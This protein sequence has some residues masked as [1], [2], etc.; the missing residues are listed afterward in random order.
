MFRNISRSARRPVWLLL[1][2][3]LL[4]ACELGFG[5]VESV[6]S[7]HVRQLIE[8]PVDSETTAELYRHM[9]NK[10]LVE[11]ARALHVQG[12]KLDYVA[13]KLPSASNMIAK[14]NVAIIPRRGPQYAEREHVLIIDLRKE[15]RKGWRV[16]GVS[17]LP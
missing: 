14:V 8:A 10:A 12:V 15:D 1:L 4:A 9:P 3:G 16:I 7:D 2:A 11:Y 5:G 13:T 6:A 17:A